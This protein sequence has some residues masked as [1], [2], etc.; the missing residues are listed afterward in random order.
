MEKFKLK[1]A[2][3]PFFSYH[4]KRKV[5]TIEFWDKNHVSIEALEKVDS[6]FVTY[7]I[8]TSDISTSMCGWTGEDK[9]GQFHFTLNILDMDNSLYNTLSKDEQLMTRLMS[10]I[11]SSVS[12]FI[13]RL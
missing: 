9:M 12:E 13:H 1:D 4:L 5:E 11:Q 7:G 3:I 2:A 10:K 8:K 6:V